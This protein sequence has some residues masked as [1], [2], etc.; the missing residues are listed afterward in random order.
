MQAKSDL[1]KHA[2]RRKNDGDKNTK[3]IH[4]GR[5]SI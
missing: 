1:E 4:D 3:D 2:N 5:L